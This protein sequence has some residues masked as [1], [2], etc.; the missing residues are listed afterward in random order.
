MVNIKNGTIDDFFNSALNTAKE[1]DSNKK[2]TPK[3]T[4]WLETD[5]LLKILK[6]Q[7]RELLNYLKN[8]T[9]VDYSVLLKEL[10]KSPS[11]LNTDLELLSKYQLIT[12]TKEVNSG[13]G[14]K[15]VIKPLYPN[16]QIEFRATLI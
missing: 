5:D 3:H 10:K 14:L 7:R 2:V 8:K 13:H 11:S 1:I 4:I 9:K 6:P 12:V 15:K 16:E